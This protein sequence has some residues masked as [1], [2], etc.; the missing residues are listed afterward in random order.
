MFIV[1][2]VSGCGP[3]DTFLS[4]HSTGSNLSFT[5]DLLSTDEEGLVGVKLAGLVAGMKEFV[6]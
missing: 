3:F 4:F 1:R 5:P 2:G 6:G